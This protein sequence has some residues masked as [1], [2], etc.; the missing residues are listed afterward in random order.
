MFIRNVLII[1][2]LIIVSCSVETSQER[3][4]LTIDDSI[5]LLSNEPK[6]YVLTGDTNVYINKIVSYDSKYFIF[7]NFD[8]N[9]DNIIFELAD[10]V[11]IKLKTIPEEDGINSEI[12]RDAG[13]INLN[14]N[15]NNS[16]KWFLTVEKGVV[17]SI[18]EIW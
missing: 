16:E 8:R 5:E 14:H 6:I 11:Q 13:V 3:K 17:Y 12:I 10:S 15:L 7:V 9:E 2:S 18:D 4:K 1:V